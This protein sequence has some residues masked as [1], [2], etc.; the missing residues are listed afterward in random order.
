MRLEQEDIYFML[1]PEMRFIASRMLA[2]SWSTDINITFYF[3]FFI[4]LLYWRLHIRILQVRNLVTELRTESVYNGIRSAHADAR[5][6]HHLMF[7]LISVCMVNCSGDR[8]RINWIIQIAIFQNSFCNLQLWSVLTWTI[9]A[10]HRI[11][12]LL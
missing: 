4:C 5:N 12:L 9:I 11:L 8:I 1:K 7:L 2:Q 10:D 6:R 3:N